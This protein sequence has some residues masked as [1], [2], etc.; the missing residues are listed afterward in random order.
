MTDVY[1]NY[2]IGTLTDNTSKTEQEHTNTT[3]EILLYEINIFE[4]RDTNKRTYDLNN[5]VTQ[6]GPK[7]CW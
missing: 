2:N 1:I 5:L 4:A 6:N 7:K 3:P